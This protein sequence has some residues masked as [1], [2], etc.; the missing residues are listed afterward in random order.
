MLPALRNGSASAGALA[1]PTNRVSSL[2]DRFFNNDDLF[3]PLTPWVAPGWSSMPLSMWQDEGHVYVEFDA[4]GLTDQDIDVSI[5]AGELIIRGERKREREAQGYD[6]RYYGQF[7]QR[8]TLPCDIDAE[9]VQARLVNGVLS[10]TLAKA[11]T[12]RPRKIAI[13]SS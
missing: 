9:N 10:L 1:H 7:Q 13:Q 8:V 5:D 4:P 2:V 12:A 11:E 6:T 3:A